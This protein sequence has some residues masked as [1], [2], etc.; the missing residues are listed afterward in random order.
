MWSTSDPIFAACGPV[1]LVTSLP[2]HKER[3]FQELASYIGFFST[4]VWGIPEESPLHPRHFSTP[5]PGKVSKSRLLAGLRQ[6]ALDTLEATDN[7]P[8][9]RIMAIDQECRK[10]QVLTLSEVRE[11]YGR[12]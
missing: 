8:P 2:E 6:A 9:E 3:E 4:A 11:R 1:T 7:Y 5:V 10:H 12:K